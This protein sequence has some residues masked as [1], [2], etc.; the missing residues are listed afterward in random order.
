ML[1]T[2]TL[3]R[4]LDRVQSFVPRI[5]TRVASVFGIAA[6]QV[7][8]T[9]VNLTIDDLKRWWV[10]VP[11]AAFLFLIANA[12]WSLYRC[13]H[14]SLKG[15]N[16][17]LIYFGEIAKLREAEYLDRAGQVTEESFRQD[18]LGQIWRNSEIVT[19]KYKY[20]RRA[21]TSVMAAILPWTLV[22]AA[23][24]IGGWKLPAI[25]Q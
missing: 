18:L 5:D 11:L 22:L 20:L 2:E 8:I 7:A 12:I 15:G 6:A 24:S 17:S 10:V 19:E 16:G 1:S 4:Q 14:P 9:V 21:S 3:E 25:S 23:V 13:T